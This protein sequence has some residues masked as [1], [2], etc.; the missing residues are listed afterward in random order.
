MFS[1]C[2]QDGHQSRPDLFMVQ[3]LSRV[4]IGGF[5]KTNTIITMSVKFTIGV[6]FGQSDKHDVLPYLYSAD[7]A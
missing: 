1:F 5:T 7:C 6:C 3:T 4:N 2:S